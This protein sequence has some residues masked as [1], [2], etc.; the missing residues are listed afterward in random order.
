MYKE[1]NRLTYAKER[2]KIHRADGNAQYIKLDGQLSYYKT[3]PY[4]D[5]KEREL[6]SDHVRF[7]Y[8]GGGFAGLCTG[9]G[10]VEAGA[11]SKDVRIIEIGGDVGGTWYW[12]RYPGCMCDS[13]SIVYMPYLE[14][15]GHIPSEKYAHAPEI[16]Y[17]VK[18]SRI[19]MDYTKIFFC[20]PRYFYFLGGTIQSLESQDKSI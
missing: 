15:T 5:F 1:A 16:L 12:N 11:N 17:K 19:S 18:K 10:V 9:A 14:E 3:D 7:C 2:D 20:K 4:I 13:A 6:V 8:I